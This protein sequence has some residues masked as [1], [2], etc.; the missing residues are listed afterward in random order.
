VALLPGFTGNLG[1]SYE[2]VTAA[3]I[4]GSF[5]YVPPPIGAGLT[6]ALRQTATSRPAT[7]CSLP[8]GNMRRQH[9]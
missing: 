2:I 4:T 6:L 8:P 9:E 1:D 3:A 7:P 5:A